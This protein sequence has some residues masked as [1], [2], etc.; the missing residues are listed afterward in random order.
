ML[1]KLCPP[2]RDR[3]G[4][5]A[6]SFVV[7]L[8]L[9]L[10]GIGLAVDY[11]IFRINHTTMQAA[12]DAGA[13]AAID[14]LNADASAKVATAVAMVTR[15]VPSDYGPVT[16]ASDVVVGTYSAEQGF[17]P[18][19]GPG[20]NA[21]QVVA[22]RSPERGNA[23][24][25]IFSVFLSNSALT[26]GVTAIAARP[27]SVFYEPPALTNL[28]NEAGDYNEIYA[29][30]YDSTGS[31]APETRRS[32]MTLISNNVPSNQN[33]VSISGGVIT[34][35]PP[36]PQNLVWPRCD[37]QGQTL[38]FRLRNVRHAKSLS[39]LWANPNDNGG[40]PGRPEY[41]HF[42]DTTINNGRETYGGLDQ[43]DVETVLCDTL[44]KCNTSVPGNIVPQGSY[45]SPQLASGTCAPGKFMY[46]G[47]ED[48]PPNQP[49]SNR[50]WTDPAWTDTDY[51]DIVIVVR[52]PRNGAL[53][54]GKPRLVG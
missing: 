40:Y 27:A 16:Q 4:A 34:A 39:Y 21:V 35:N 50:N 52:C 20:A 37:S 29:Y 23:V 3:S 54:N 44:D 47:W 17:V 13:L 25:R 15:N 8:P 41:N 2:R 7:L 32:Q 46:F 33:I 31:G 14:N 38:S 51:N 36:A 10:T 12:V 1:S 9:M 53:G 26:I 6:M 49:G 30:C 43:P 19:N 28:D 22:V 5:V 18:G 45:R 24:R 48:R 11:S 42:T